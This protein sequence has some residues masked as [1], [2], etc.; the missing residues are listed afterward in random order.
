MMLIPTS[1][2]PFLENFFLYDKII[3]AISQEIDRDIQESG[4]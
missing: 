4:H 3:Y 2:F 1:K